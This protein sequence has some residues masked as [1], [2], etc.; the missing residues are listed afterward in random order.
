MRRLYTRIFLYMLVMLVTATL[1][2]SAVTF[3]AFRGE[4]RRGLGH[5]LTSVGAVLV[6]E[7]FD[8]VERRRTLVEHL[9]RELDIDLTLRDLDGNLLAAS[10]EPLPA[11][12]AADPRLRSHRDGAFLRGPRP[13]TAALV[14]R[15]G[16]QEPVGVLEAAM[17]RAMAPLLTHFVQLG[18]VLLVIALV[19]ALLARRVTRPVSRLTEATVRLGGG[20]LG[21][22]IRL[23]DK[24]ERD[25]LGR[26]ELAWNDMAGR[27]EALIGSHRELLANVSHEL[28]SP[29][30]RLRVVLELLP[31]S[32]E[33]RTRTAEIER[34]LA[35][36][37][38]LVEALLTV[39]RLE[40]AA[41]PVAHETVEVPG[42]LAAVRARSAEGVLR[43]PVRVDVEPGLALRGDEALLRRALWNLV[44]NAGKYG[45]PPVTLFARREGDR[46]RV[47]VE[48]EGPGI[49]PAERERVL[50]PFVRGATRGKRGGFGLGLTLASRIAAA[51]GGGLVIEA[52]REG[53]GCR[54]S[55]VAPLAVGAEPSEGG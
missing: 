22:R 16:D 18:A 37:D 33:V 3:G 15:P 14:R 49:E 43:E 47:G 6:G 44:E 29:L 12:D 30:A 46:V 25:E 11:V 53:R 31:E 24:P 45:A 39:A 21:Y 41:L 27:I 40:A 1:V 7:H 50:A 4:L 13:F 32:P 5:R 36:L 19:A 28:R 23:G 9:G 48:D 42:L 54:V 51:H 8:D 10:G 26:L 17:P 2:V 52:G 35:D 20:D 55:L 34:E 38:R